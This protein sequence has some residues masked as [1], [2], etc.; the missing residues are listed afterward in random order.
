MMPNWCARNSAKWKTFLIP[1]NYIYYQLFWLS[2][3]PLVERNKCD[4]IERQNDLFKKH[5]IIK[6]T[7]RYVH[8]NSKLHNCMYR[9]LCCKL[10]ARIWQ[11]DIP[12]SHSLSPR[13][14]HRPSTVQL[15]SHLFFLLFFRKGK[16]AALRIYCQFCGCAFIWH[17]SCLGE[18]GLR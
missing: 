18:N 7:H 6:Y 10:F 1:L 13:K 17:H 16:K 3:Q 5:K 2:W 11:C 14:K 8:Q 4:W 15:N 9:A 12:L